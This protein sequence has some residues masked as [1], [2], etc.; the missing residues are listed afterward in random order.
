MLLIVELNW[1]R[2][3]WK[4]NKQKSFLFYHCLDLSVWLQSPHC[5]QAKENETSKN[6]VPFAQVEEYSSV[7]SLKVPVMPQKQTSVGSS[8]VP[9]C[10][11]Q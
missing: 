7:L 9:D 2:C 4:T 11:K 3:C 10:E 1:I 5:P 6:H 8:R